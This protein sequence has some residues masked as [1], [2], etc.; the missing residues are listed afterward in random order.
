MQFRALSLLPLSAR[1][2]ICGPVPLVTLHSCGSSSASALHV[3]SDEHSTLESTTNSAYNTYLAPNSS[4]HLGGT[5]FSPLQR[6]VLDIS[7]TSSAQCPRCRFP[8]LSAALSFPPAVWT[9]A[10]L[11]V[12]FSSSCLRVVSGFICFD[13]LVQCALHRCSPLRPPAALSPLTLAVH[14]LALLS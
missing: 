8:I 2:S 13:Y 1:F 12:S 5:V 9:G 11:P 3:P 6:F 10:L 4:S 7:F 14:V